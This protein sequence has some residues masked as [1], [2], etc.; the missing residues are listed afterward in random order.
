MSWLVRI[1][2]S[3]NATLYFHLFTSIYY[4]KIDP[5][6]LDLVWSNVSFG[7]CFSRVNRNKWANFVGCCIDQSFGGRHVY[8]WFP[9]EIKIQRR[10]FLASPFHLQ[11]QAARCWKWRFFSSRKK[12][13]IFEVPNSS[14]LEVS[15]CYDFSPRLLPCKKSCRRS[16]GYSGVCLW[17]SKRGKVTLKCWKIRSFH[18]FCW[19]SHSNLKIYRYTPTDFVCLRKWIR[20]LFE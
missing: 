5:K 8:M 12:C 19:M 18:L 17:K 15:G 10:G 9:L 6:M 14:I 16:T 2:R 13:M 4:V 20:E 3:V 1:S 7:L 11:T